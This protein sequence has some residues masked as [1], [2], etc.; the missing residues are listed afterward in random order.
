MARKVKNNWK[1]N[2]MET[3]Q[4]SGTAVLFFYNGNVN[5]RYG[6]K[7]VSIPPKGSIKFEYIKLG[8]QMGKSFTRKRTA[9]LLA[10]YRPFKKYIKR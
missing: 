9:A 4:H 10:K 6:Y 3:T 2:K 5:A 7:V 8:D 1:I